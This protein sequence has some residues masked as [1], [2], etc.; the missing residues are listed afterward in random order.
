V[1]GVSVAVNVIIQIS[2]VALQLRAVVVDLDLH[3]VEAFLPHAGGLPARA[4]LGG[5]QPGEV[6]PTERAVRRRHL[7]PA[8][9]LLAL[10]VVDVPVG[11]VAP[12][13]LEVHV[14]PVAGPRFLPVVVA[15]S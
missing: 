10:R 1:L 15:Q 9:P 7:R 4:A 5:G 11:S 14:V 8:V 6:L 3:L 2:L 12:H 13:P